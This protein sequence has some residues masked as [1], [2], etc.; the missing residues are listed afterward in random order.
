MEKEE[1]R[2]KAMVKVAASRKGM[3][4]SD[5]FRPATI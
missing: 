5:H 2:L 3:D 4:W 1:Q